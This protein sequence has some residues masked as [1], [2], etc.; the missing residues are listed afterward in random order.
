MLDLFAYSLSHT[1]GYLFLGK[2]ETTRPTKA[3][4]E[5]IN[6]KWKIYRCVSWPA[7]FSTCKRALAGITAA[8][9]VIARAAP[10]SSTGTIGQTSLELTQPEVEITQLRRINETML[11]CTNVAMVIIDRNYRILTINAAA[12]RLLGIREVGV[13]SG[14][15]AHRARLA[16]SGSSQRDRYRISRTFSRNFARTRVGPDR[17]RAP[18]DT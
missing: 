15:P 18:D 4:F 10:R 8:D 13:R 7:C 3:R 11:R 17:Q 6:K 12:R 5:L 14:L 1:R 9:N 16:L 2:A